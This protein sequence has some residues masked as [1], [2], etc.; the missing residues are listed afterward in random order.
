MYS[1]SVYSVG[2]ATNTNHHRHSIGQ[3]E[4]CD[5]TKGVSGDDGWVLGWQANSEL[6]LRE[7]PEYVLLELDKA[8]GLV[9]CLLDGGREA[10]P[11]LAVGRSPLHQVVG[12]PGAAIVTWG[13][14]GQQARLVGDL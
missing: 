10:V 12:H 7:D 5:L 9:V 3:G 4:S 8:D 11:D 2:T 1:V 14:P 13:V 6:V